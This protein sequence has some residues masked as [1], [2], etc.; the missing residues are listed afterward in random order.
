MTF[1]IEKAA[2]DWSRSRQAR[3]CA[4]GMNRDELVDHLI[5]EAERLVSEGNMTPEAAF[6]TAKAGLTN[7]S[8]AN[9]NQNK[10]IIANA[11]IWAVLMLATGVVL[12]GST[13]D[14]G[15]FLIT[16]VFP[17]LWWVS[18]MTIRRYTAES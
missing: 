14:A 5:C 7:A 4:G 13:N 12:A 10:A 11:I 15:N 9:P 3:G 8:P 17:P 6:E 16:V 2:V 1:S 18:D